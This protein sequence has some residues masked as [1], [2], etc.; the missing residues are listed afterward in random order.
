MDFGDNCVTDALAVTGALDGWFS[1][2]V[3]VAS[4]LGAPA[5]CLAP[6]GF[7]TQVLSLGTFGDAI[8]HLFGRV[9][10]PTADVLGI[11]MLNTGG[12][13]KALYLPSL[14]IVDG[15]TLPYAAVV[16][17][18]TFTIRNDTNKDLYINNIM[19][20]TVQTANT[21][22]GGIVPTEHTHRQFTQGMLLFGRTDMLPVLV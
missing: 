13:Y 9:T 15:I 14:G 2:D 4:Y 3:R 6:G 17:E 18:A 12:Q 10:A 20:R 5:F 8:T 7:M 21:Q 22:G 19:L 11:L 1:E 16:S